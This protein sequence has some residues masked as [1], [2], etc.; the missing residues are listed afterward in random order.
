LLL[1][2]SHHR[3]TASPHHRFCRRHRSPACRRSGA[4]RQQIRA[5]R[6]IRPTSPSAPMTAS[7]SIVGKPDSYALRAESKA[8]PY[9]VPPL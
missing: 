8:I 4:Q 1:P 7:R 9:A 2:K 3:I 6:W 5:P